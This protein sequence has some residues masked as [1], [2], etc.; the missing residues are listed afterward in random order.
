MSDIDK[1]AG[2]I[3]PDS[4]L[5]RSLGAYTAPDLS[6]GFADRIIAATEG[7]A[8]PL[9]ASRPAGSRWRSARRLAVGALA[10][11]ALGT[12]AAATGVLERIGVDLPSP[13]EVWSTI[14]RSEPEAVPASRQGSG[15]PSGALDTRI[16]IEGPVDTPEEL[17]EVF[18]R[19]DEIREERRDIRR[20]RVDR[21]IDDAIER[22]REQ[23]LPAPTPEREEQMRER[24]DQF[25]ERRDTTREQRLEQRR[26]EYRERIENGEELVPQDII[27]ERREERFQRPVGRRLERLRE[28]SPEERRDAIR[29]FRERREE[30]SQQLNPAPEE[31]DQEP[32]VL[33]APQTDAFEMQP[34][35]PP[36]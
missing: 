15:L 36:E 14:T 4:A 24:L 31:R 22:R 16:E 2:P 29:R 10:A 27:R 28:M 33:Q 35:M 3:V 20:E 8:A 23:G 12:A 9:P 1:N 21:L 25:R 34:E 7:R 6:G 13:A 26:E 19:V 5:G 32:E 18:R 30:M 11:G 17:E